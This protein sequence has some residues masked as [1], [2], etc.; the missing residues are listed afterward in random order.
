MNH[1]VIWKNNKLSFK[2]RLRPFS[3]FPTCVGITDHAVVQFSY[4]APVHALVLIIYIS[5]YS[6]AC[7]FIQADVV[8]HISIYFNAIQ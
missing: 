2:V 1:I 6:F 5:V 7:I 3:W 4:L 8:T